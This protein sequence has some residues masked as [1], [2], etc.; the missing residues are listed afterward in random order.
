LAGRLIDNPPAGAYGGCRLGP[1]VA[2][3]VFLSGASALVLE[4]LWFRQA[5]LALGSG[6]W[7]TSVVLASFMAGLALGNGLA[8]RYGARVGRPLSAYA[9]LEVLVAFTGVGL[10]FAWPLLG[11]QLTPL[12]RAMLAAPV[13]LNS[14]RL[15][16][17]FALMLL[18]AAAMGAT[19][20]LLARA[21]GPAEPALG[22]LLGRL[23]GWNTLGAVLGAL[24]AEVFLVGR[25]G[26]RGTA[27]VAGALSLTAA[28]LALALS[29]RPALRGGAE[30]APASASSEPVPWRPLG[31]A[32]LCGAALLALEV[33]WFRF[34]SMF[35]AGTS[36]TFVLMLAVVL[37]GIG[38]GGF[39]AAAWLRADPGAARYLRPTLA[40]AGASTVVTYAA[41]AGI[42]GLQTLASSPQ[43]V[44][45]LGLRLM[46]PVSLLS[47]VAFTLLGQSCHAGRRDEAR[48]VGRLTLAN[49][50]G[51]LV[52][53]VA[54]GFLLLPLLG[55][56]RSLA[57]LA[58][59]YGAAALLV[60]GPGPLPSAGR[61]AQACVLACYALALA[62]FPFG[63]MERRYFAALGQRFGGDGGRIVAVRE[64]ATETLV[65]MR[66][67][68]ALEPPV[69]RLVTNG[70]SMSGTTLGSRRY[71]SLYAWWPAA[72]HP[73]LRR[74]L[75]ISYGV[76][77][78]AR[79][80]TSLPSLERI[81][82]VDT[83]RD[84]L[85]MG[86]LAQPTLADPLADGRVRVHVE[87]GR[88]YLQTTEARYDLITGEPPPPH[89]AGVVNLYT[90]EYFR[91]LQARLAPGGIVTYWL[92]VDQL[93]AADTRA[94]LSAFCGAF[95][96]C[97]LWAGSGLDWMLAATNGAPGP[98]TEQAF[99]RPWSD[100]RI[101]HA[102]SDVGVELPEQLGALFIGDAA[103]LRQ[104]A[105]GEPPLVDDFPRR[106]M[107]NAV[108]G[109]AVVP[110]DYYRQLMDARAAR[111]RFATSPLVARLWPEAL[112]QRTLDCF[113]WQYQIDEGFKTLASWQP[114]S[115]AGLSELDDVL[116][117]STL[118]TLALWSLGTTPAEQAAV[119]DLASRG[120]R[121]EEL[122]GLGGLADRDY[123]GAAAAFARAPGNANVYRRAYALAL[124]GREAEVR[125]LAA[126]VR[127][128]RE[129]P[130]DLAFWAWMDARFGPE[131]ALAPAPAKSLVQ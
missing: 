16:I 104:I 36:L 5:G 58:L 57:V 3:A 54:G 70:F 56:E 53:S 26:I 75:L 71:M 66:R 103:Y 128:R 41:F 69:Y 125:A 64:G 80:L 84:V 62:L 8:A 47:G 38:C 94:I 81:D 92:P 85:E 118:R 102:L 60:P 87:D 24:S 98:M 9:L 51:A 90:L 78:T 46:L 31:A 111:Q 49:T 107:A 122:L 2:V 19:L 89:A 72:V 109:Q 79:A 14:T 40:A 1:L 130:P 21:C 99:S 29:R 28:A 18:P 25:Y 45:G 93:S 30:P 82:V 110:R 59:A 120:Q 96:D 108:H 67:D 4:T 37:L 15:A 10:V 100:L 91:L 32:F 11:T 113:E 12:F 126:E 129:R 97:S 65:Y 55:M 101:R 27:L 119:A 68:L 23:Y 124:A 13:A 52:G 121:M 74:A 73:D 42:D 61:V 115:T 88:Q 17:A 117:R 63:L 106:I 48:T 50:L 127:A 7:A 123:A 34:L 20:P 22:R 83:S 33:V 44:L 114:P 76:G 112:R 131:G 105:D 39:A 6:V 35:L 95:A 116:G 43:R 86:R 77:V